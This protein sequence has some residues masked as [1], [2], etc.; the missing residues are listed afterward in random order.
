M[1]F[2]EIIEKES[3][4]ILPKISVIMS[5]YND[6][7]YIRDAIRSI[8]NQSFRDFEFI[9]IDD[10]SSDDTIKIIKEFADSRIRL[11][12]NSENQG[13]TKNLNKALTLAMGEYIARMD[14]DDISHLDRFQKQV[15][16][17][18]SHPDVYLIGSAVH[19]FGA[20]D[21]VWRLPDDSE[22]LK[23]RMLLRPVF[24][25]PSFMFRKALV[26]EG[27]TY[28]ESFR[29]AQDYD[30]AS[31]VAEKY[32]IGR[33]QDILLEYRIHQK[34]ISRLAGENQISNADRVRQ[35]L[36]DNLGAKLC[37][38]EKLIYSEWI[39]EKKLTNK[40]A[41]LK[42][43]NII[44]AICKANELSHIYDEDILEKV[45]K[46]MLYT[47]IIRSKDIALVMS[48]PYFC[49]YSIRD[50]KIFVEEILRTISE[51]R[52]GTHEN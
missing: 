32:K 20:S 51:K 26:N 42:A 1:K 49:R 36:F 29:T 40:K 18:D 17:L 41:Y 45:L 10:A 6:S 50:M 19:S 7:N 2:C 13:L 28:D 11:F 43:Y 23:V 31:R 34:Q 44:N 15:E 22:E 46:K 8:L 14:G 21:L 3:W 12:L 9:I 33:I 25:H 5:T 24:A 48:F 30:F 4:I 52:K 16:Y 37:G 38:E 27:I 35:R 39:V 47:W